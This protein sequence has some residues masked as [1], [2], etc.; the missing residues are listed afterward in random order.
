MTLIID[1]PKACELY[2]NCCAMIDRHNRCRQKDLSL[3]M[4]LVT[5]D[6][7][8]RINISLLSI[9]IV[10]SWLA[11]TGITED[12]KEK[13]KDFYGYLAEEL[14]DNR[15]DERGGSRERL[16]SNNSPRRKLMND[17]GTS[18]LIQ[19]DGSSRCGLSIHLTPTKR[20]RKDKK[21][22]ISENS[23]QGR[24]S[25]CGS[26]TTWC[27]SKCED[28]ESLGKSIFICHPKSKRMCFAEHVEI[29]ILD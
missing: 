4:K 29:C 16:R 6:W 8:K 24:C 14:I 2:Y 23:F 19:N 21:G 13:Q 12:K 9:C 11:Y 22:K 1:Q 3:E 18:P 5:R 28:D 7:S 15:Y 10:D 27:C 26:K 25:L 17:L 20:K